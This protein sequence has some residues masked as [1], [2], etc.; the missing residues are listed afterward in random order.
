MNLIFASLLSACLGSV[1]TATHITNGERLMA[2]GKWEEAAHAFE[3]A[4]TNGD[5]SPPG[6]A[7]I[8]WNIFYAYDHTSNNIDKSATALLSFLTVG[9]DIVQDSDNPNNMWLKAFKIKEKLIF[10]DVVLQSMWASRAK[11]ACREK[12][13]ACP[14]HD[15]RFISLYIRRIPFCS[16]D[17]TFTAD[18]EFI[19]ADVKCKEGQETYYF[20]K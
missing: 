9:R 7:M 2:L 8:Y 10:A 20:V 1:D 12:M 14:Y 5:L 16:T 6:Q 18:A 15:E 19:R 17:F 3:Q 13:F 11:W 4:L